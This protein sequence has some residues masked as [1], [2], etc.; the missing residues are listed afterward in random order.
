MP[1]ERIK[2]KGKSGAPCVGLFG[3]L[4][5]GNIGNDASME[6]VLRYFRAEYPDAIID[7]MGPGP[8]QLTAKYGIAAIPLSW[9]HK[10]EQ[11]ASGLTAVSLKVLGKCVDAVRIASWV[12]R[13]DAVIVPGMGVL[14]ASLPLRPWETPYV[15]FM[16]CASG[17][18]FR[19]KVALVSVGANIIHQRSTRWL[20]NAAA[21]LAYYRSY[22]DTYS[23][24]AMSQ[25]G[26]DASND[27]VYPDLVFAIPAPPYDPG[28]PQI[29]GI[30][31][32]TYYGT[33]DDRS[34]SDEIHTAYMEKIKFFIR[35]LIEG[36]RKIRLFVGDACDDEA[37]QEILADVRTHWPDLDP[38]WVV[39]E[40][41]SSFAELTKA[42]APAGTVVATR[43]HNVMCALKLGKPVVSLGYAPKNVALMTTMGLSEFFQDANSLDVELLIKQ[44]TEVENQFP[45]LRKAIL[46]RSAAN[47]RL[48]D[49]Q[50]AILSATLFP[51]AAAERKPARTGAR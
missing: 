39:A 14:E 3:L 1:R 13:H 34:R 15:M 37:L 28:D 16:A 10:R 29:V 33:N 21:R 2:G 40:P 4:G 19:T 22:R 47:A 35:W 32:M 44:F 25:R 8:E 20:Y 17:R 45:E 43:F 12:R 6:A 38:S 30:G 27:P 5:A 50:F 11:E 18:L 7:A 41:V 9:H 24:D 48:L 26:V 36:G 23:R 49:D 46:E 51:A 31:V 42:M